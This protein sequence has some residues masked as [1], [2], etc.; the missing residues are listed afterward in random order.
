MKKILVILS[1][2]ALVTGCSDDPNTP[3]GTLPIVSN[4]QI[5]F[6]DSKGDTVFM[7]WDPLNVDI[8]NYRVW[9]SETGNSGWTVVATPEISTAMHI[10]ESSGSYCVDAVNGNDESEDQSEKASNHPYIY[11]QEDSMSFVEYSGVIF[12]DS[13]VT[14]GNATNPDFNQDIIILP[15]TDTLYFDIYRGNL[16]PDTYPGGTNSFVCQSET[17]ISIAPEP[18]NS[19]WSDSLLLADIHGCYIMRNDGFF[20]YILL[21]II[22]NSKFSLISAQL[23]KYLGSR[24]FSWLLI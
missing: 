1:L 5:L 8:D 7:S 17:G 22:D 9:Y 16:F 4:F 15:S 12:N 14:F 11:M 3:G 19:A 20:S 24:L 23:S 10:A 18:S 21:D 6:N 13:T 2:L